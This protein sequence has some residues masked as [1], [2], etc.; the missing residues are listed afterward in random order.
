MLDELEPL[1]KRRATEGIVTLNRNS[2]R[3]LVYRV[4]FYNG[5]ED[6][7]GVFKD[8]QDSIDMV[9]GAKTRVIFALK[10]NTPVGGIVVRNR[11]LSIGEDTVT[12]PSVSPPNQ[13]C[14]APRCMT[15]P[16]IFD[17]PNNVFVNGIKVKFDMKLT[18]K[19]A[20]VIYVCKCTICNE[21]YIGQTHQ[22]FHCRINGHRSCFK[23]SEELEFE[24]SALSFHS[25]NKHRR[26]DKDSFDL[27]SFK[28]GLI[29][30]APPRELDR[31]ED[32]FITIFKT[33]LIGLN[34]I[35][36]SR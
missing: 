8:C 1:A 26:H 7:K 35:A 33:R 25:F 23:V 14:K 17:N 27:R 21:A 6:L 18:C 10:K 29:R 28:V 15:C 12:L 31:V 34:R 13:R 22:E 32:Y 4:K 2:G 24:K 36:V 5:I 3:T 11:A 9:T 30:K 16:L 20:G 19:S